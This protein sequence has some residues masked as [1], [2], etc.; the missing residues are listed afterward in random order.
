MTYVTCIKALGLW[1]GYV[2]A[3]A[4][5]SCRVSNQGTTPRASD[6]YNAW[7]T[8]LNPFNI[9]FHPYNKIFHILKVHVFHIVIQVVELLLFHILIHTSLYSISENMENINCQ[10]VN[11]KHL[12]Q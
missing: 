6:L 8:I 2:P 1:L 3:L 12:K 11:L 10:N 9:V 5:S 7:A 4:Y